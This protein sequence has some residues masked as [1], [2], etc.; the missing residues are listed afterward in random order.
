ME[1]QPDLI[2][3]AT[4]SDDAD[5]R[6]ALVDHEKTMVITPDCDLLHDFSARQ[7]L[8]EASDPEHIKRLQSRLL[9]HIQC[10]DLYEE[11]VIKQT[12]SLRSELWKRV[13]QNQDERYHRIPEGEVEPAGMTGDQHPPLFLDFKGLF[14]I[15][16]EFLYI[17]LRSNRVERQ[18]VVPSPWVHH[19]ASRCF[20]FHG[21]VCVPDLDVEVN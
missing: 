2:D 19:I 8:L 9:P 6:I 12:R 13:R 3:S 1:P 21:R 15:P 17:S 16:T 14:S 18:G 20:N 4:P 11:S 5:F 10:C 7:E